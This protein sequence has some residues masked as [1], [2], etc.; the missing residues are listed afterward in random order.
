MSQADRAALAAA[1]RVLRG[2][3]GLPSRNDLAYG[4]YMG[5]MLTAIVGVPLLR[6]VVLSLAEWLPE[7][8]TP[9]AMALWPAG[10]AAVIALAA[11]CGAQIGPA[12]A[13]LPELDLLHTTG[14]PR[15]LL[16]NRAL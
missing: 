13:H 4:I 8:P 7:T 6:L 12:R 16:F 10:A 3:S 5:L 1:R 14:L 9:A 11:L 2:R 15:S